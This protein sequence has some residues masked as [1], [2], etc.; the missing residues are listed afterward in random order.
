MSSKAELV[1]QKG[2][3][4]L[5]SNGQRYNFKDERGSNGSMDLLAYTRSVHGVEIDDWYN[6]EVRDGQ[7]DPTVVMLHVVCGHTLTISH[8]S[9]SW[10]FDQGWVRLL[11]DQKERLISK[12]PLNSGNS[13]STNTLVRYQRCSC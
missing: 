12:G 3:L 13:Y 4:V 8:G 9:L 11:L 6:A 10:S 2:V 1:I 7:A 5:A